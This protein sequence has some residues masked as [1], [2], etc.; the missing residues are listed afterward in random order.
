MKKFHLVTALWLT[1]L[2]GFAAD[3]RSDL[4]VHEWGTFTSVQGGDGVLLP[5]QPF[6][7]PDLP[8]FVYEWQ[9][10]GFGHQSPG[11]LLKGGIRSLQ[12]ME[13]P[14]IY[15]YSDR[16]LTAD[17]TVN[18]PAGFITEWYPQAQQIGSRNRPPLAHGPN[19]MVFNPIFSNSVIAWR[20]LQILPAN[21]PNLAAQLPTDNSDNHYFAARETDSAFVRVATGGT[22]GTTPELEKLLFYRGTGNFATPLRVTVTEA[23]LGSVAN[24]GAQPLTGLFLVEMR[25]GAGRW[26][27]LGEL[28][29]GQ[30]KRWRELAAREQLKPVAPETFSQQLGNRLEK[31]L[32]QA[33]LFPRE[34]TAMV[35]TWRKSWFTEEGVRLLYILP[36]EWT[37]VTLPLT[38]NPQPQ[39]LERVMVGRA[40]IIPPTLQKEL[41]GEIASAKS[42]D[43]IAE[44]RLQDHARK[45]GRFYGPAHQL[46]SQR[47]PTTPN[48]PITLSKFE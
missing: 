21:S 35:K 26:T 7:T 42:G 30:S 38:L 43:K 9:R 41:A 12:R 39:K 48:Q 20:G 31:A 13:T 46:A 22:N 27:E 14:V 28:L 34:A 5:W 36:R 40:E 29:P 24:T 10:P 4:I 44:Q 17:V 8:K 2:G 32:V 19:L 6:I 25:H 18:F 16:E 45:L 11:R 1:T 33:G 3:N 15:F 47:L 23:G 37:D